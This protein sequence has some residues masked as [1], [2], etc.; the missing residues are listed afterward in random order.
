MR[1]R[2]KQQPKRRCPPP[3]GERPLLQKRHIR[4]SPALAPPTA[5]E[6][7][8]DRKSRRKEGGDRRAVRRAVCYFRH[9]DTLTFLGCE[10][11]WGTDAEMSLLEE[12]KAHSPFL[13]F[14]QV[15]STGVEAAQH[16]GSF[17]MFPFLPN[18][19]PHT[20]IPHQSIVITVRG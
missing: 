11:P 5:S 8:S 18:Y 3:G 19:S 2:K 17:S 12:A 14:M 6:R 1:R 7:Y 16:C 9:L 10:C 4:S 20:H 15:S 13:S